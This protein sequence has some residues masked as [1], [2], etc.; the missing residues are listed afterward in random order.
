MLSASIS[1]AWK[2]AESDSVSGE[3]RESNKYGCTLPHPTQIRA[4]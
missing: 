2:Y 3:E 4:M 1:N